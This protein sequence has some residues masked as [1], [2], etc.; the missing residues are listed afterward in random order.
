MRYE[1]RISFAVVIC[2]LSILPVMAQQKKRSVYAN[3]DV[4]RLLKA[5]MD[6]AF[7]ISLI[8]QTVPNYDTS[9][10]AISELRNQG[11]SPKVIDAIL[12]AQGVK[13]ETAKLYKSSESIS[14]Q[15]AVNLK[16]H[17]GNVT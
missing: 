16:V 7:I 10:E 11:A 2:F 3:A 4:V 12:I 9:P 15:D 6:E 13:T 14:L 5:K 1:R 8:E 17:Y